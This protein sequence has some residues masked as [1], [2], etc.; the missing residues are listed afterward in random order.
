MKNTINRP[1]S[2]HLLCVAN[3]QP[4]ASQLFIVASLHLFL[5]FR[6]PT[7]N[8]VHLHC[9]TMK[10]ASVNPAVLLTVT[11]PANMSCRDRALFCPMA[12]G[13]TVAAPKGF[14]PLGAVGNAPVGTLFVGAVID[15]WGVH[16]RNGIYYRV[17]PDLSSD[18]S[19]YHVTK[20]VK[21]EMSKMT[22]P[23]S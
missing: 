13:G 16:S 8:K 14:V 10:I 7:W 2:L 23:K 17:S 20:T 1:Q 12:M 4:S 15:S 3:H 5:F 21:S 18:N 19:L 22:R 9:L 11:L 6:M